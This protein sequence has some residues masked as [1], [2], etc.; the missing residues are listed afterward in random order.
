M[1]VLPEVIVLNGTSSSGKTS[2]LPISFKSSSCRRSISNFSIDS[3]LYA[4]CR[5][6][7]SNA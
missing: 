4:L 3:I 1:R 2:T 7:F 6:V 5:P